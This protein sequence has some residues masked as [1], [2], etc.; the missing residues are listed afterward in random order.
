[1]TTKPFGESKT[2]F[3][4]KDKFTNKYF[5]SGKRECF[6]WPWTLFRSWESDSEIAETFSDFFVIVI[7]N[8]KILPKENYETDEENKNEPILN[9]NNKFENH[10]RIKVIKSRKKDEQTFTLNYVSYE[11]VGNYKLRQRYNK[12]IFKEKF[13]EKTIC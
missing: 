3:I 1:M 7:A 12:M 2:S 11:E 8:L 6:K 4:K 9:Y 5:A 10:S 13:W